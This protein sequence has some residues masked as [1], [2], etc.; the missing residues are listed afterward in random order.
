MQI[1]QAA[2]F[3]EE[4]FNAINRHYFESTLPRAIITI[5]SSPSAYG[6]CTLYDAWRDN[7]KT[8]KEINIGAE[9]LNRPL[10]NTIATLVHEMVHLYCCIN[11]I[12][13]T[14]RG[15]TYHNKRFKKEAEKRGLII[16]YDKR[17]GH[18]ITV[19]SKILKAF[20]SNQHWKN[21]LTIH[22]RG[23]V[24]ADQKKKKKPSSTR[25]LTCPVCGLS[26][27]ATRDVKV[28]CIDCNAQ[29]IVD[30]VDE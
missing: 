4:A 12:K 10:A 28:L 25:K 19:P 8:Y 14:S 5:Q 17:I 3:L 24:G 6:H 16:E 1:S 21:K 22:R 29:L 18:S 15:G 27:R 11:G 20:I 23:V 7:S 30:T 13:D 9:T 26:V 2:K